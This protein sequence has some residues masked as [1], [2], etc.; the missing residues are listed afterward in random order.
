MVLLPDIGIDNNTAESV[1]NEACIR[2][3]QKLAS[4]YQINS[5]ALTCPPSIGKILIAEAGL[6]VESILKHAD[7]SMYEHKLQT[8]KAKAT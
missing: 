3:N 5:Q 4:E 8:R 7:H 1:L 6:T 2:F